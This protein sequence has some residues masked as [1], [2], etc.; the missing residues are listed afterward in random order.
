LDELSSPVQRLLVKHITSIDDPSLS[1]ADP[2]PTY[3]SRM[4]NMAWIH[5]LTHALIISGLFYSILF[6]SP[7]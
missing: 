4:F 7:S 5:T 6:V 1:V 2:T 3:V